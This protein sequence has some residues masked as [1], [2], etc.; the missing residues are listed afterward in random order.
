MADISPNFAIRAFTP[1]K[2][3]AGG[4]AIVAPISC[5]RVTITNTDT[6]NAGA[7][8]TDPAAAAATSK[9]LAASG[10]ETIQAGALAWGPNTIICYVS[11]ENGSGPVVCTFT[12]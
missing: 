8:F 9:A 10:T 7:I 1:A 6:V 11:A 3:V 2:Q 4:V 5:S 12:R